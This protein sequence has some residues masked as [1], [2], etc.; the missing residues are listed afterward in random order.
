M[1]PPT[2][3]T[4]APDTGEAPNNKDPPAPPKAPRTEA[5]STRTWLRLYLGENHHH[6][7]HH[8]LLFYSPIFIYLLIFLFINE[9]QSKRSNI[10]AVKIILFYLFYILFV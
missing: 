4:T 6:H 1:V 8:H 5:W 3:P 9:I 10:R 7:H 2:R